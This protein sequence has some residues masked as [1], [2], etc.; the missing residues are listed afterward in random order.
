MLAGAARFKTNEET[1][2]AP[3]EFHAKDLSP[4]MN[5]TVWPPV[6]FTYFVS[7]VMTIVRKAVDT[8]TESPRRSIFGTD[9][10]NVE[11]LAVNM[12]RTAIKCLG[13]IFTLQ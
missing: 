7:G 2:I 6:T 8:G 10:A 1:A 9:P 11:A 3:S 4:A 12:A 5:L 13:F